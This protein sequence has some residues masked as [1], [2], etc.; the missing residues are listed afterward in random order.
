MQKP[1][2]CDC[3]VIARENNVIRVDFAR[4]PIRQRHNFP[5]PAHSMFQTSIRR[6]PRLLALSL[7]Q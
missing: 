7:S 3:H 2:I 6:V 1:S 4:P 5:V